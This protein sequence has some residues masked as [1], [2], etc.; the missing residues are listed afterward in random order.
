[1][2]PK[3]SFIQ[4]SLPSSFTRQIRPRYETTKCVQNLFD[5]KNIDALQGYNSSNGHMDGPLPIH[6]SKRCSRAQF[7][8]ALQTHAPV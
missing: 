2:R 4:I 1:M 5:N 3:H 6:K 7:T 8:A